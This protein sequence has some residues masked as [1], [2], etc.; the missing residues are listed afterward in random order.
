MMAITIG[1]MLVVTTRST[2]S[3]ITTII[4]FSTNPNTSTA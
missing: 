1:G 2:S 3:M 4:T